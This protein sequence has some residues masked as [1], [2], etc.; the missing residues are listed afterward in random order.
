MEQTHPTDRVILTTALL[1]LATI[2]GCDQP[3]MRDQRLADFAERSMQ[4][5]SRQ[6]EHIASQSKAVVQE[7][8]KLAEAA[9]QLIQSD[10]QARTE[11]IAAQERL[12]SQLD[13]QRAKIDAGRDALEQERR[14]L[15]EQRH[16]DPVVAASIRTVGLIAAALLPLLVCVYILRQLGRSEP[17]DAAVAELLVHELVSDRPRLLPMPA[18]RPA[19]EHHADRDIPD[20]AST[21][22]QPDAADL[23]F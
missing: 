2:I 14:Q 13:Q 3:D 6:N 1:T 8:Q 22:P 11:M 17:D 20:D 4:E 21:D 16:R 7:S 19:L 9:Q 23:P 15:A 12:T 10:A 5:Q 18:L